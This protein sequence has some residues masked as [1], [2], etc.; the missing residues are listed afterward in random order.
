MRTYFPV[1]SR[2]CARLSLANTV[3][4]ANATFSNTVSHGISE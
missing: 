3:S 2:R 1:R 4:T